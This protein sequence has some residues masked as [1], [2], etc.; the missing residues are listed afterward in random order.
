M[1]YQEVK[2]T[3][4]AGEDLGLCL[5]NAA[6]GQ[7]DRDWLRAYPR[8][9]AAAVRLLD[10]LG[11]SEHA[12]RVT[13]ELVVDETINAFMRDMEE[14][15]LRALNDARRDLAHHRQNPDAYADDGAVL[16]DAE[17]WKAETLDQ[18]D[19]DLDAL[20]VARLVLAAYREA[21]A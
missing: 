3:L 19:L 7:A 13:Y 21:V 9:L 15:Q 12:D 18:V 11:W 5:E 14:H 16:T 4:L 10:Q 20:M 8:R 1:L 2:S 17:Q 6:T